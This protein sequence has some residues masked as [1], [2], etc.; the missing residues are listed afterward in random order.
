MT[1]KVLIFNDFQCLQGK[2]CN[3]KLLFVYPNSC[4]ETVCYMYISAGTVDPVQSCADVQECSGPLCPHIDYSRGRFL[5][6]RY[7]FI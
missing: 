6:M 5:V 4:K 2:R 3:L 7:L 1:I